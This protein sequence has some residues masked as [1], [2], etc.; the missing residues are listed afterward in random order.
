MTAPEL[1][2]MV[3]AEAVRPLTHEK[4]S[5]PGIPM[6]PFACGKLIS[7]FA[8]A[9][10][11]ACRRVKLW[12]SSWAT[13]SRDCAWLLNQPGATASAVRVPEPVAC[14]DDGMYPK[15]PKVVKLK[16]V[17]GRISLN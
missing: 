8:G 10:H 12:P 11:G 6:V 14:P 1:A 9:P 16:P 2:S 4:T 13:N 7:G 3:T 15:P 17:G 5:C